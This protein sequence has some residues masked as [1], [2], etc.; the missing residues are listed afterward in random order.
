MRR[1]P[2]CELSI[3]IRK[4]EHENRKLEEKARIASLNREH[5]ANNARMEREEHDRRAAIAELQRMAAE[6]VEESR[7]KTERR[8]KAV[9]YWNALLRAHISRCLLCA[10]GREVECVLG[11]YRWYHYIEP[12]LETY[13]YACTAMTVSECTCWHGARVRAVLAQ[14]HANGGEEALAI[15]KR[16]FPEASLESGD[17]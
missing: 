14:Y 4:V 10:A 2:R 7:Q 8:R 3:C 16:D 13:C 9:S 5:R 1:Q 17:E 15:I 12:Q 11:T 6:A